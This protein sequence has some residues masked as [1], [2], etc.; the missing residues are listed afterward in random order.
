MDKPDRLGLQLQ[1]IEEQKDPSAHKYV[2]YVW[3]VMRTFFM[4]WVAGMLTSSAT[5][6]KWPNILIRNHNKHCIK[7]TAT[8]NS[9]KLYIYI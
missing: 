4:F 9:V 1:D 2:L 5:F 6:E 7:M 8:F 3:Y